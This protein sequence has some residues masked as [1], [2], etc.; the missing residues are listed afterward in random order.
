MIKKLQEQLFA[1]ERAFYA[2]L[3]C[4]C[5][6]G[7]NLFYYTMYNTRPLTMIAV[8]PII[9]WIAYDGNEKEKATDQGYWV[10]VILLLLT[11]LIVVA[12]P[13]FG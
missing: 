12:Y 3:V 5:T 10:W 1:N 2:T 11:S 4:V 7:I 6:L 13:L 8:L 9:F